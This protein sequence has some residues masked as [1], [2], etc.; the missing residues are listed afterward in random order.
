M[1]PAIVFIFGVVSGAVVTF[2][3]ELLWDLWTTPDFDP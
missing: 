1:H 3:A 2:I